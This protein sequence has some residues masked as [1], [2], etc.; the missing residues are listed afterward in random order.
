MKSI[1]HTRKY[2]ILF[3]VIT[4]VFIITRLF[5]LSSI[6][7]SETGIEYD[8]LNAAYD[9]WCIQGWGCDRDLIRF[10]FYFSNGG[11]GQSPLNTYT[12]A[13]IFKLFGFSLFKYRMVGVLYAGLAYI[14]LFLLSRI[15]WGGKDDYYSLIPISLM[16]I[17]PYYMMSEH[18]GLDCYLFL[19]CTI[20]AFYLMIRAVEAG[21]LSSYILCGFGWGGALYSYGVSYIVL[22]VFLIVASVYLLYV[23]KTTIKHLAAAALPFSIL[24]L[25]LAIQQLVNMRI[26]PE[27]TFLFSDFFCTSRHLDEGEL[28]ISDIFTNLVKNTMDIFMY[29]N[30]NCDWFSMNRYGTVYYIS[31]PFVI[32]GL[33]YIIL[34][35]AKSIKEKIYDRFVL[36][37][38]LFFVEYICVL[39]IGAGYR[40][41]AIYFPLLIFSATGIWLTIAATGKKPVIIAIAGS[42]IISFLLFSRFMYSFGENS[43]TSSGNPEINYGHLLLIDTHA[44]MAANEIKEKYGDHPLSLIINDG[45][46]EWWISIC[47]YMG[48]SP[49]EYQEYQR[50]SF[51]SGTGYTIGVPQELDLSGNT[52]YLIQAE[53]GHI[54]DYL[55]S[56]GFSNEVV[57]HGGYSMLIKE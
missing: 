47:L 36:V 33:I 57:S 32:I 25:P 40:A 15:F 34:K 51:F 4:T 49:D 48:I 7:F 18:W 50:E 42:Y 55:V 52:A 1:G 10:P 5:R 53:L 3:T 11:N 23:H 14:S 26:L 16:T 19:S 8:E 41:N 22:P 38:L 46:K 17:M 39:I 28:V 35:T 31:I 45:G 56:Q 27:F 43:W 29:K 20:I 30:S 9:A 21:T 37:L 6:P 13:L 24:G 54:T 12:A 2:Y 44:A